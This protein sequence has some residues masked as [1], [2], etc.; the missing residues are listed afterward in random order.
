MK[1]L[2]I[3]LLI[4]T[5]AAAF[6]QI[7]NTGF[8]NWTSTGFP[9]HLNPNSWGTLNDATSLAGAYTCERGSGADA[10]S[11]SYSIKLTSR[12]IFGQ[13]APGIAVTG[14]IN[15]GT[16]ALEGGFA[17]AQR[18]DFLTGWYKYAPASGDNAEIRVTLWRRNAGVREDVG[19]GILYPN[20]TVSSFAA[21]S[22]PIAYTSANAPDS[23]QVL[24]I[25]TNTNSIKIGSVLIVDD[26][27]FLSCAGF[28][29]ALAATDESAPGAGDGAVDATVSGGTAGY[30][31]AWDNGATIEDLSGLAPGNYCVT[32]TDANGCTASGCALVSSTSCSGF[33]V[34]VSGNNP[35][36]V[37]GSDGDASATPSGGTPPYSFSWNPPSPSGL[38]AGEYCVT[39]TD[40][41][42]CIATG[43]VTLTDPDCSAFYILTDGAD[44]SSGT[45][46][47]G[48]AST[49]PVDGTAPYAYS[50]NN[51]EADSLNEDVPA[52]TYCVTVTDAAG[53]AA[54]DCITVGPDCSGFAA[55]VTA[56]DETNASADDG[57]A[58]ASA[59]G[60]ATPYAYLW[61]N[62]AANDSLSGLDAGNYCVTVTDAA[63]CEAEA[64]DSVGTGVGIE[65][66]SEAGVRLFPNPAQQA[67]TIELKNQEIF[68][69]RLF[70]AQGKMALEEML[71]SK[72][73]V[74]SLRELPSGN[75]LIE[76]QQR[77]AGK[78]FSGKLLKE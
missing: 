56:T 75:Y 70:D 74:L 38:P 14:T 48:F 26:L 58:V 13:S 45:A 59:A 27:S 3:H 72:T 77:A 12:S 42:G 2:L 44:A 5:C 71:S 41:A 33:S 57:T 40:N 47:D 68:R 30:T 69:L 20:T 76:L 8:E 34:S 7:P 9:A 46:S 66:L 15:T 64:C 31:Y 28:S 65:E 62:A 25:S 43:C 67:V 18:P 29:V 17:Y 73:N 24:L 60:G 78:T 32:V 19:E 50:W 11:G 37:G 35:T 61:N 63:G 10:H 22:V 55:T 1:N 23:G 6:A 49:T 4:C 53:C 52:G 36:T 16:Q 54:S 21:F 39:V 51:S